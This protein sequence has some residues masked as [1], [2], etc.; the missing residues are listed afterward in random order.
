MSTALQIIT[1]QNKIY[2]EQVGTR[3]KLK[4]PQFRIFGFKDAKSNQ[5]AEKKKDSNVG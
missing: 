1:F 3:Q 5:K 2:R 4:F